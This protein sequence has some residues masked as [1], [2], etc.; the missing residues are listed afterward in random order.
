MSDAGE[1][2]ELRADLNDTDRNKKK[3]AVKKIIAYMTVGKDVSG[4][5]ADVL[6]NMQTD[7]IELK[8]LTYLYLMNY[9]KSEPELA[10]LAVN[11]FVKDSEDTNP[12]IRAL[13]IR[14]M[15]CIRVDKIVDYLSI[16]LNKTLRDPE[17]YVRKTAALTVAKLFDLN[18]T[19][20]DS[21]GFLDALRDMVSDPNA[22]VVANA[23]AALNEINEATNGT[24]FTLNAVSLNK[25]LTALNEANEWGQTFMLEAL[26]QHHASNAREAESIC[27]RVSP[28]LTHANGA[29]ALTAI[30]VILRF[31]PQIES[32]DVARAFHQKLGPPLISMLSSEPEVQYIALRNINLILRRFPTLLQQD[33]R[34]FFCKYNDLPYIKLEKLEIIVRLVQERNVEQVLAELKEYASEVDVAFVRRAIGAIG[35]CALKLERSAERCITTLLDLIKTRVTYVVQEAI[36]IIKDIFRKYPNQYESVIPALCENLEVLDEPT[37]RGALIWIIGEYGERIQNAGEL[38]A[39][40]VDNFSEENVQVQLQLLTATVKLFLKAPAVAKDLVQQVLQLATTRNDNPDLRDR[41]F[42]YWRL[43]SSD[44]AAARTVVLAEK[45]PIDADADDHVRDSLLDDL[46]A[47]VGTLASV[48]FKPSTAFADTTRSTFIPEEAEAYETGADEMGATGGI[49]SPPPMDMYHQQQPVQQQQQATPS[50]GGAFD[51]LL[52]LDDGLPK[53]S[54]T[55]SATAASASSSGMVDIMDLLGDIGGS[56]APA[57]AT[58]GVVGGNAGLFGLSASAPSSSSSAAAGK[59]VMLT[60]AQGRGL[61]VS[62]SLARRQGTLFMDLR[63]HNAT[64][65]QMSDFAISFNKNSFALTPASALSVSPVAPGQSAETSL[66]L[67]FTGARNKTDPLN[68][69]QIAI[70]N[71]VQTHYCQIAVPL[72]TLFGDDGAIAQAQFSQLWSQVSTDESRTYQNITVGSPQALSEKL[73]RHN[74]FVSGTRKVGNFD[75]IYASVKVAGVV[76]ILAEVAIHPSLTSVKVTARTPTT[77]IVPLFLDS[78]DAVFRAPF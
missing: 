70:K 63:L 24:A 41:G 54:Y 73:Q 35:G 47:H 50:S 22:M 66:P 65:T 27:E 9:A 58:S 6:K 11:T 40:F 69:L 57:P 34:V 46:V 68:Q 17:P 67:A 16:P 2:V 52:D 36:V 8:K 59:Q 64:Q 4:V 60:A 19:L 21:N 12:L 74:V 62:Y 71:N 76:V 29:V 18:P 31:A 43:L 39:Q 13:S 32:P 48:Y 14:T 30:R 28:R 3:D 33:I 10:I 37:A 42:I 38:L 53:M 61:E 78:L 7:D 26:A 49:A 56:S 51:N 55:S 20:C 5:F 15:G 45:L 1:L 75:V 77:E 44:P 25:L 23:M 72:E